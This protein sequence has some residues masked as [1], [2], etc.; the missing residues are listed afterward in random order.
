MKY[1]FRVWMPVAAVLLVLLSIATLLL[2]ILPTARIRLGEYAQDQAVVRAVAAANTAVES[3]ESDL[4]RKLEPIAE[5]GGGEVLLVDRQGNIV[6][7]AGEQLLSPPEEILQRAA[8]G[9][10]TNE[11]IEGQ[12]VATVPLVR[13]G[14][15]EGGAIFVAGASENVVYQLFVRSGIEAAGVASRSFWLPSSADASSGLP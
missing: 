13:E 6:V 5:A 7:R 10:R 8:N 9:E 1:R 11:M 14:S 15:L 2:Y 4:Q 3:E 12:R